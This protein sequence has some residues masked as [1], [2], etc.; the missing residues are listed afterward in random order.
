MADGMASRIKIVFGGLG[1]V[2]ILL[3]LL[4]SYANGK[5]IHMP[6]VHIIS[7]LPKP[8]AIFI[9]EL[10]GNKLKPIRLERSFLAE[11]TEP[12]DKEEFKEQ[13]TYKK[14]GMH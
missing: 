6:S 3:G 11:I 12:V 2:L 4:P 8:D 13:I 5:K 10:K 14:K 9:G 1:F 7:N